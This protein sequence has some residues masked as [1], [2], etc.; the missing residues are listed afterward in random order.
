MNNGEGTLHV[1][2][3]SA[4]QLSAT[5]PVPFVTTFRGHGLLSPKLRLLCLTMCVPPQA[6]IP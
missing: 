5:H 3:F 4:L 1:L 2:L 6:V